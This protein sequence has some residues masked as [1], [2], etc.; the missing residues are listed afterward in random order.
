MAAL[1]SAAAAHPLV[2]GLSGSGDVSCLGNF[3]GGGG[4]KIRLTRKTNVR[5][6]FGVDPW[7]A[8]TLKGVAF[9]GQEEGSFVL[10]L[11]SLM[12]V[13]PRQ[14]R[15]H[16]PTLQEWC[17]QGLFCFFMHGVWGSGCG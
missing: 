14:F 8:D 3:G 11:G 9:H 6:R 10:E 16:S 4:K 13:S 12:L 1:V 15:L 2:V 17:M 7:G 5:K